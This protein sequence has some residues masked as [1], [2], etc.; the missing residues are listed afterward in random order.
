MVEQPNLKLIYSTGAPS[1]KTHRELKLSSQL[2]MT[3]LPEKK[4]RKKG[5]GSK[6]LCCCSSNQYK[7]WKG[8]GTIFQNQKPIKKVPCQLL[9]SFK[10]QFQLFHQW[11]NHIPNYFIV[12]YKSVSAEVHVSSLLWAQGRS[13]FMPTVQPPWLSKLPEISWTQITLSECRYSPS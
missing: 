8:K 9:Y 10:S 3:C 1:Q 12:S 13:G 11:L 2:H 6:P 7:L 5:M 4:L